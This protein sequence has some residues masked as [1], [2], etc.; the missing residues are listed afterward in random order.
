MVSS[1]ILA[2][3][4]EQ[5]NLQDQQQDQLIGRL[6]SG[7]M[8]ILRHLGSGSMGRVY[9]A[10]H[11]TL[12][13]EVA[14]KVLHDH[15]AKDPTRSA[16][17]AQEAITASKLNH[18]NSVKI[19]DFGVDGP[20]NLLYIAM[21]LLEGEDLQQ[22]IDKGTDIS[23]ER[24]CEITIQVLSALAAAHDESIIHRDMKPSNIVLVLQRDDDGELVETVKVCDFGVAKFLSHQDTSNHRTPKVVGTPLYMSPEQ[25]TGQILDPRTDI[26][27]CG[28]IMYEMITGQPPF[29][30]DTAMEV[31]IKHVQEPIAPPSRLAPLMPLKLE[32]IVMWTLQKDREKRPSSCRKLRQAIRDFTDDYKKS[33]EKLSDGQHEPL[34]S[35]NIS[36]PHLDQSIKA[37]IIASR[38]R[39]FQKMPAA[40]KQIQTQKSQPLHNLTALELRKLNK[41][42]VPSSESS[43]DLSTFILKKTNKSLAHIW[44]KD[45]NDLQLGPCTAKELIHI[46]AHKKTGETIQDLAIS[47]DRNSWLA[48]TRFCQLMGIKHLSQF[49]QNTRQA[50][51]EGNLEDTSIISIFHLISAQKLTGTLLISAEANN[52]PRYYQIAISHG[53][54]IDIYTNITE[55]HLPTIIGQ[56]LGERDFSRCVGEVIEKA[57]TLPEALWALEKRDTA[58][59]QTI[60]KKQSLGQ[61][62]DEQMGRYSFV[63]TTPSLQNNPFAP[64][65]IVPLPELI[66]HQVSN[67]KLKTILHDKFDRTIC[68]APDAIKII[69]ELGLPES[70]I[71]IAKRIFNAETLGSVLPKAPHL[72]KAYLTMAY[73]L[74]E[75]DLLW[76]DI[77]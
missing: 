53:A 25:A 36:R 44:I 58:P 74:Q 34:P 28:I 72:K 19:Y 69:G 57:V 45:A 15:R 8:R 27:A 46:L 60:L 55:L 63:P 23:I 71:G 16:S 66:Y 12:D 49:D 5:P 73:L 64:N 39:D 62:I 54:P 31:L 67:V 42:L 3:Q 30:A 32:E 51:L 47:K 1:A 76:S 75:M 35:S 59:Y 43:H 24:I 61:I 14:I 40:P 38:A 52:S 37:S 29:I 68:L 9:K 77:Q 33:I 6:I 26:Y 70:Q 21:E 65:L 56:L 13:K 17:F 2:T 20:D 41:S 7:K 50:V 10:H 11:I 22:I 18:P 4:T 48:A